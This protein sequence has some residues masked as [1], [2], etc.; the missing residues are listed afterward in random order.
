MLS[1]V[2]RSTL[3][4][5]HTHTHNQTSDVLSTCLWRNTWVCVHVCTRVYATLRKSSDGKPTLFNWGEE[6]WVCR[7]LWGLLALTQTADVNYDTYLYTVGLHLD[8]NKLFNWYK[9]ER[10]KERNGVGRQGELQWEILDNEITQ[11][12]IY[13]CI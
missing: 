9:E 8:T 4:Y 10:E 12:L 3:L 11:A 13:F 7:W 1:G 2:Q 6:R 5:S